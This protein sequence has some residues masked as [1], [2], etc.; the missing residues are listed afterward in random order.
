MPRTHAPDSTATLRRLAALLLLLGVVVAAW[1]PP[2]QAHSELVASTPQAGDT[3]GLDTDRLVLV[4]SDPL[5]PGQAQVLVRDGAGK[6]VAAGAPRLDG[7]TLEVPLR[8]HRAGPHTVAYRVLSTDGHTV[9]GELDFAVRGRPDAGRSADADPAAPASS[10]P[11][12]AGEGVGADAGAA[13][14]SAA[15][16]ADAALASESTASVPAPLWWVA[17]AAVLVIVV[18]LLMTWSARGAAPTTAETSRPDPLSTP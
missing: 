14:P 17:G 2:A 3:V 16:V 13:T 12:T 8:L 15:P 4:F 18:S 9:V 10:T 11:D 1:A 5:T 7:P 6:D